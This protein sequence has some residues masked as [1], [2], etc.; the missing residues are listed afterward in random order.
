M[1]RHPTAL[2]HRMRSWLGASALAAAAWA[3]AQGTGAQPIP[4]APAALREATGPGVPSPRVPQAPPLPPP[5]RPPVEFF[6]EL[7]AASPAR[8]AQLLEGKPPAARDVIE[9]RIAEFEAM[10]PEARAEATW[11][12][13]LAEFRFYLSSLLVAPADQRASRLAQAPAPDRALLA[14]RLK[15]WDALDDPARRQVLE[16]QQQFHHFVAQP[17]ADPARLAQVLQAVAPPAHADVEAQFTRWRALP[18]AERRQRSAAF[19]AVF[20]LPPDRRDKALQGLSPAERTAMERSLER[21]SKLPQAERDRC[22]SGLERLA[23]L[24]PPERDAFLRSAALWQ[25]MSPAE[26]DQWRR[27]VFNLRP[28]PLPVPVPNPGKPTIVGTNR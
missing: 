24:A 1:R 22:I 14:E 3:Q 23:R 4:G 6:R 25:A 11:R 18:E 2:A 8:R 7:L 10:A 19:Q 26:R 20:D 17:T 9:R 12:L 21:F 27:L 28:P 5:T 13:R 16:S 15:T